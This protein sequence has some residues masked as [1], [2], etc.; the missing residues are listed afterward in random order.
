M[1]FNSLHFLIFF[2]T[3]VILY[4]VIPHKYRWMVLLGASYYFYMSWRI[5]YV[6]LLI[7]ST[8][9]DYFSAIQIDKAEK[10]SRRKMFLILSIVVNIGLLF[11]FKYFN[12][13]SN[14][15]GEIIKIFSI[16]FTPL[17]LQ[18]LLPL[19]ISFYTFQTLGY[20]ID[21]YRKK[22]KPE[23]HLGI[24][25]VYVSFF[26]QLVAGPI[27]RAKN[28]IPQFFEK[29]K[30]DYE[31]VSIGAK[32]M[33]WGFFKKLVIADGVARLVD[34][35]FQNPQFFSEETLIMGTIFFGIQIYCDFSGYTDIALGS[36]KIMGFDLIDNFKRPYFSKNIQA[37]WRRWHIS[38]TSWFRDYIYIPLG[39][40]RGKKINWYSN[41]LIVFL[42]AGLWHGA[43]W[44][45][46]AWGAIHGY[47][48]IFFLEIRNIGRKIND[49]IGLQKLSILNHLFQAGI[50]FIL[51]NIGWIFF[52]SNT[53]NDAFYI[54]VKIMI[55]IPNIYWEFS[56]LQMIIIIFIFSIL[57]FEFLIEYRN[58]DRIKN[59]FNNEINLNRIKILILIMV[60][61][62][63]WSFCSF[64]TIRISDIRRDVIFS[65]ILLIT[66]VYLL[67]NNIEEK[68]FLSNRP[69]WLRWTIYYIFIIYILLFGVLE[70]QPFIYFQF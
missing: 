24:L 11:I 44:T 51:V 27:E 57:L 19:G 6:L 5:E 20:T 12:F 48:L 39:G 21:V 4:F 28:L 35:V 43:N 69:I 29:H 17:E 16:E 30:F 67:E 70:K 68:V 33:L 40:N 15:F 64:G 54:I 1:L 32:L 14:S 42:I 2:P 22:I 38:L 9:V 46:L 45:F 49:Y 62:L 3:V 66:I 60:V 18:V 58:Y 50:V 23:R 61:I 8:L 10:I 53:V 31:R 59:I 25:A 37:F 41:I 56:V 36:A 63:F 65:A 55:N 34:V 13:F 47:Y 26:P 52:R 7:T